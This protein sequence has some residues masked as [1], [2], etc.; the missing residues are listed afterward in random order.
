MQPF[1]KHQDHVQEPP[2]LNHDIDRKYAHTLN[3]ATVDFNMELTSI[4]GSGFGL[5][6]LRELVQLA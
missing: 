2:F 4:C 5:H 1:K 3:K 6:Y